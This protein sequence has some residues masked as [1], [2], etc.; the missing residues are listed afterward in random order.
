MLLRGEIHISV[1]SKQWELAFEKPPL[2]RGP[3]PN[4]QT[5]PGTDYMFLIRT[6]V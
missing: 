4:A 1:S 3:F 2:H 5:Q 6:G